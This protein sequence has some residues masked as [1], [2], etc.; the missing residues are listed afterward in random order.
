MYYNNRSNYNRYKN[1]NKEY[2]YSNYNYNEIIAN[3]PDYIGKN[4]SV[5]K[6]IIYNNSFVTDLNYRFEIIK[7]RL[8]GSDNVVLY[9]LSIYDNTP[10]LSL[11]G[12]PQRGGLLFGFDFRE[13]T[14]TLQSNELVEFYQQIETLMVDRKETY[15]LL[16]RRQYKSE[17][18][19]YLFNLKFNEYPDVPVIKN[20]PIY[21]LRY[22]NLSVDRFK[23]RNLITVKDNLKKYKTRQMNL[24]KSFLFG[25]YEFIHNIIPIILDAYFAGRSDYHR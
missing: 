18:S 21:L 13:N 10:D 14:S 5:E 4:Y 24:S 2:S 6:E 9:L 3:S 19:N 11:G 25:E 1:N 23:T 17:Y 16:S 22:I 15:L 12:N 8:K 7:R 20:R